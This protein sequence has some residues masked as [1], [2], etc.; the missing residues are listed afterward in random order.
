MRARARPIIEDRHAS[1]SADLSCDSR[2][3]WTRE[4]STIRSRRWFDFALG[5][6]SLAVSIRG[7]SIDAAADVSSLARKDSESMFLR[8][9][10]MCERV[11]CIDPVA[12][13]VRHRLPRSSE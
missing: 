3:G 12:L 6:A 9:G 4:T 1:Q 13:C 8:R 7:E 10:F 5:N 2:L 11:W